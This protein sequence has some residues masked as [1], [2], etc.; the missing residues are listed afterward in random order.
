MGWPNTEST[1]YKHFFPNDLLETGEDILFFWVA[2]MVMMSLTLTGK[3]P[4]KTIFLHPILRDKEGRKM[5]KSLGNIIDP[6]QII[7]GCSIDDL[8]QTVK[9]S[10]LSN[11]EIDRGI[12]DKR[13]DFPKGIPP[14][15]SDALRFG[16]L[17]FKSDSDIIN[18]RLLNN[19]IWNI[20]KYVYY[21][22]PTSM[23]HHKIENKSLELF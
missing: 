14:C 21:Y 2:R 10:S 1:D 18:Y 6:L 12:K 23:S 7:N 9:N 16:L 11:K 3:V 22:C 5:S 13:R 4:F 20:T 15:G 19:K 8:I 17:S